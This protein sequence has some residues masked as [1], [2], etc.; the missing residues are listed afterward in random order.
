MEYT[1]PQQR[2]ISDDDTKNI[3]AAI[4]MDSEVEVQKIKQAIENGLPEGNVE[5]AAIMGHAP[6]QITL[7]R[8]TSHGMSTSE[9]FDFLLFDP[10]LRITITIDR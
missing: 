8:P 4:N 10:N 3:T 7:N 5:L 2:K 9:L 1:A 6:S